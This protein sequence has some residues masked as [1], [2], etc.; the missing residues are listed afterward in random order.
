MYFKIK[1]LAALF[2][3]CT[4]IPLISQN[5][6]EKDSVTTID[7]KGVTVEAARISISKKK[8]PYA[9]SI[10]NT[11]EIDAIKNQLSIQEYLNTIPGIYIQN[12]SNFAQDARISIRGAGS[13]SAFGIRGIKLIVDGIPETTPDGQGQLDNIN[14]DII[15]NIELVRSGASALY[16]NASGGI[17]NIKTK[18]DFESPFAKFKT[19]FGSYNRQL[20]NAT[21]G[22]GKGNSKAVFHLGY[23]TYDGY[24]DHSS[25]K[26]WN[27]NGNF[28]HRFNDK[29]KINL[30]VN[31]ADSP[32]AQDAGGLTREQFEENP[33]QARQANIDFNAGE[34]IS[35][36]K[37]GARLEWD[38]SQ[39]SVFNSYAFISGRDF[40]G[41]LP[42]SFGG[43]V[44][45]N[46]NYG[47]HG[48]AINFKTKTNDIKLGYDLAFQK[49]ER[50]RFMNENGISGSMTLD[51]NEKFNSLGIYLLDHL[52]FKKW[53]FYGG[54]RFDIN[55][56]EVEDSFLSN[57]NDSSDISLNSF[58]PTLGI[59]YQYTPKHSIF[60][61][62]TT[63]FE[64]PTLSELSANPTGEQGFNQSLE[65]QKSTTFEIGLKGNLKELNYQVTYFNLRT[66]NDLVPFELEAFPDRNFFRNAGSTARNGIETQLEFDINQQ[67]QLTSAYTYSY[68]IFDDYIVNGNDRSGN[69]LPGIPKHF[70]S[71]AVKYKRA[72]GFFGQLQLNVVDAIWVNDTNA[73]KAPGYTLANLNMGY[74]R[75]W[76]DTEI[77]PFL[78]ISNLLDKNYVDNVRINAFGSRFYEPAPGFQV[79]GGI[80]ISL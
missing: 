3:T 48:S 59:N 38:I 75:K 17:I 21:A 30:L 16:G 76:G 27:F 35:Q 61:N 4:S 63:A 58:N 46:R 42:F 53:D 32:E 24:R 15:E 54:M 37:I 49:D 64:T 20:Y 5:Q 73:E 25:F 19:T 65:P 51:Q 56:L 10:I 26:Q 31:Y 11:S 8:L 29:L 1:F 74:K 40:D 18:T 77:T 33:R 78:G 66:K 34:A 45:L 23:Q 69:E 14:L 67:W 71:L 68:F 57:G 41:R 47:G 13:R 50:K 52:N 28:L 22:I 79:F 43:I 2:C 60:G 80:S 70:G 36:Y 44:D 55:V 62:I 7:L 12:S 6:I 72:S 39:N 9:L